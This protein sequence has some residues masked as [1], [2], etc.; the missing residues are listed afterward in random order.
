MT[1]FCVTLNVAVV[2]PAGIITVAGTD[3]AELVE[4]LRFIASPPTGAGLLIVTVPVT[5]TF[6]L[7]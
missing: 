5:V 7:P 2:F 3:A 1:F 6:A 4:L